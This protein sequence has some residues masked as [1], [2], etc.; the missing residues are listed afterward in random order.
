MELFAFWRLSLVLIAFVIAGT[1]PSSPA[2]SV[3][4]TAVAATIKADVAQIV[5]G[6]NAH[7]AV[8]TTAYDAPDI[9][10]MECGSPSTVGVEADR[11][12]F[13]EGFA[14]D[15]GWKVSLIDET[16]DVASSGDLAVYRGTYNEDSSSGGVPMTHKTNFIA[17]FKR[18]SNGP[19]RSSGTA[20]QTWNDRIRSNCL[21]SFRRA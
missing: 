15:A 2:V 1:A 10:S 8:K 16:V 7:D 12:G 11:E 21:E 6:I 4:I 14:R 19:G 18:Q 9:I 17:E 13:K 5:A 3:D 20:F